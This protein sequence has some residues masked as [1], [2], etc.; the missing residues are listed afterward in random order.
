MNNKKQEAFRRALS[1]LP[2]HEA[3]E[4][5]WSSIE[6]ELDKEQGLAY[7]DRAIAEYTSDVKQPDFSWAKVEQVLANGEKLTDAITALPQHQM[8]EDLFDLIIE[9]AEKRN[10]KNRTGFLYW[11]SGIA[12]SVLLSIS[13]YWYHIQPASIEKIQVSYSQEIINEMDGQQ[14]DMPFSENDEVLE[15]IREN[16]DQLTVKCQAPKFQGLLD[17]YLELHAAR[18]QLMTQIALHQEQ[19]QLVS[20]LVRIEKEKT[21]VGKQLIQYLLI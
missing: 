20:Y 8:K 12:A 1:Q 7:L 5:I 9:K 21:E 11:A 13:F 17:E 14:V 10:S 18:Q 2:I 15:F 4:N 3:P 6:G 19:T 16:C